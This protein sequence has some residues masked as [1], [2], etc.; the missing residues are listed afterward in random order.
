MN[1][2]F[3]QV[4]P[5]GKGDAIRSLRMMD[6]SETS[7]WWRSY[8]GIH[9]RGEGEGGGSNRVYTDYCLLVCWHQEGK[10]AICRCDL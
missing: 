6:S 1:L 5:P 3:L 8:V 4:E 2:T 9:T 7:L 10:S